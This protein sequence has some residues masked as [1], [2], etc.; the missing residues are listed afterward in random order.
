MQDLYGQSARLHLKRGGRRVCCSGF[1]RQRK[2][3]SIRQE[4]GPPYAGNVSYIIIDTIIES[5]PVRCRISCLERRIYCKTRQSIMFLSEN[6]C[7]APDLNMSGGAYFLRFLFLRIIKP[8]N[9]NV[10]TV[11]DHI[12]VRWYRSK[13]SFSEYRFSGKDRKCLGRE[14]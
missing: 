14:I 6:E 8:L 3:R 13:Y 10:E 2:S 5:D 11:P 12:T 7:K 4:P 9:G 1:Y